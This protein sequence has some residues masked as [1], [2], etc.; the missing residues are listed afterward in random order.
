[1]KIKKFQNELMTSNCYII[2]DSTTKHSIIIDPGSKQSDREIEYIKENGLNLDYI[3]ITHE[4]TDHNWGVNALKQCFPNSK[5]ICSE[6]CKENIKKS[7]NVYFL[8]YYNDPTY[9]YEMINPDLIIDKNSNSI[10]WHNSVLKF[11]LTPG[12]SHGSMCIKIDNKIFGGDTL[13][14]FSP[15]FNG[16]DSSKTDW[17]SSIKLLK[18]LIPL[19]TIIYPGH[20]DPLTFEEWYNNFKD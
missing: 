6:K 7:N 14:P 19:K 16:R 5:V 4:H 12:H 11:I 9:K 13:M 8:F 20:G 3:I 17:I 2:E 10:K 1:M 18:D 15:Y